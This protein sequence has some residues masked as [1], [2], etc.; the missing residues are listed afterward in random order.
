MKILSDA[1]LVAATGGAG[2]KIE[3]TKTIQGGRTVWVFSKKQMQEANGRP[4][5]QPGWW[6]E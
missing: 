2:D 5:T 6:Q 3:P 4:I 1:E